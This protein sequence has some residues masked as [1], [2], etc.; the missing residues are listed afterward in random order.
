MIK[1]QHGLA[2]LTW[3][4][5]LYS[6]SSLNRL[7]THSTKCHLQQSRC[8][9]NLRLYWK[10]L[11]YVLSEYEYCVL[12]HLLLNPHMM[13]IVIIITAATTTTA[14]TTIFIILELHSAETHSHSG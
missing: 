12:Q 11:E 10:R 14:A 7:R 3:T 1:T 6:V 2:R 5:H 4:A 8:S 9:I 13:M